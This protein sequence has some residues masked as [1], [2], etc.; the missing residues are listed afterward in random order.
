MESS[1][2][3]DV[4]PITQPTYEQQSAKRKLLQAACITQVY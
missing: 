4:T 3:I 1:L 2:R